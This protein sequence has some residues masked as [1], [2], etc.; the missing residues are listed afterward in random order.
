MGSKLKEEAQWRPILEKAYS[1][2]SQSLKLKPDLAQAHLVKGNLYL[3]V[4]RAPD[5]VIEF[6]EYLRLDPKGPFA[7]QTRATTEKI[8]KALASTKD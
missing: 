5:A 4:G 7:E 6:E 2:V 1:H 3:K 8:K